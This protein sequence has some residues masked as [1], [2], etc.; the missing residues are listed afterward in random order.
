MADIHEHKFYCMSCNWYA[1]SVHE[2]AWMK[3]P[4]CGRGIVESGI[5]DI[6][7]SK[8]NDVVLQ[9]EYY[10]EKCNWFTFRNSGWNI[11]PTLDPR[12]AICGLI[13]RPARPEDVLHCGDVEARKITGP[14]PLEKLRN[15][16]QIDRYRYYNFKWQ[17]GQDVQKLLPP[18]PPETCRECNILL[19]EA[20]KIMSTGYCDVCDSMFDAIKVQ[21]GLARAHFEWETE[22]NKRAS[23]KRR[24]VGDDRYDA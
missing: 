9:D 20:S 11:L 5:P 17:Y 2:S 8:D 1:Y 21:P 23:A 19:S 22:N 13:T 6:S 16:L 10:C 4:S 24:I 7:P 15:A 14:Q 18:A 3:C 12:C